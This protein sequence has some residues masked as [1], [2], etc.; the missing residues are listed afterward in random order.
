MNASIEDDDGGINIDTQNESTGDFTAAHAQASY[1]EESN[2]LATAGYDHPMDHID[3]S[4]DGFDRLD[5][6]LLPSNP[7]RLSPR[8]VTERSEK[9]VYTSP[10]S[11][12]RDVEQPLTPLTENDQNKSTS[13]S[14]QLRSQQSDYAQVEAAHLADLQQRGYYVYDDTVWV[15]RNGCE[16]VFLP[17]PALNLSS[18]LPERQT[19]VSGT[20]NK[21]WTSQS[22]DDVRGFGSE[23]DLTLKQATFERNRRPSRANLQQAMYNSKSTPNLVKSREAHCDEDVIEEKQTALPPD[24]THSRDALAVPSKAHMAIPRGLRS[25]SQPALPR[26]RHLQ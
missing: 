15:T 13:I 26:H 9:S 7:R 16:A 18:Q 14:E 25:S 22:L 11:G 4:G 20:I 8:D 2:D 21:C 10:S 17:K 6:A 1:P 3:D 5:T 19:H 12:K 23:L 24:S